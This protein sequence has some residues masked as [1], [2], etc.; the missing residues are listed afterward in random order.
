MRPLICEISTAHTPESLVDQLRDEPSV[1]LLRSAS[2][3]FPQA[4]YS[5]VT[6][7]PFLTFRSLGSRC[8][9]F[10][11][12]VADASKRAN[13][14]PNFHPPA[15]VGGYEQFGN[16]WHVLDGLMARYE[17]LDEV[18][19]PFPLGGCFG[20]WGY[21]LKNFV[22]PKL[23]RRAVD[24]LELPD[25]QVGFYDSLVVFDHHLNKTWIVSTG[26]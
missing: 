19:L 16:P 5:F 2:L 14:V 8:E 9:V 15:H 17:L 20:Y 22:E 12:V 1:V 13:A 18:D 21:D 3:D 23:T 10:S 6:A 24:D 7:R 25:C 4:R 26:L 11:P